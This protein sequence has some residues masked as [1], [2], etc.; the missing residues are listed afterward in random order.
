LTPRLSLSMNGALSAT[1]HSF[2]EVRESDFLLLRAEL[3]YQRN[4]SLDGALF[5]TLQDLED[6]RLLDER[7]K[8]L[9]IRA[10]WRFGKLDVNGTISVVDLDR[11]IKNSRDVRAMLKVKRRFSWR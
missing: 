7:K 2:P 1:R 11:G 8:G 4:G 5:A 9:G 6:S 3:T 10:R